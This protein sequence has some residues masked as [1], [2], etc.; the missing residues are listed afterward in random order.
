MKK[1]ATTFERV[2]T[3]AVV[4]VTISGGAAYAELDCKTCHGD[5]IKKKVVHAAVSMGCEACHG[6]IDTSTM[7]HKANMKGV[8]GL[9]SAMP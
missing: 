2:L 6:G 8:K 4:F 1:R 7:P 9:S 3:A 5:L